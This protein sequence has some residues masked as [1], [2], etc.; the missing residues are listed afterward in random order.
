MANEFKIKTG[1]LINNSQPVTGITD[2]SSAF[3]NYDSSTIATVN[4]TKIYVEG[5]VE[6]NI[7]EIDAS[8]NSLFNQIINLRSYTD[9]SLGLR[10][11]SINLLFNQIISLKSYT[12]SSLGLRDA[13][14]NYVFN[15]VTNLQQQINT[16]NKLS[17]LV[18]AGLVMGG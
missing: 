13:S 2:S 1:L 17:S 16:L 18:F 11:A 5:Y 4:A 6:G 15:Q 3:L 8:I 9:A 12:D 10:D 7:N 14:L